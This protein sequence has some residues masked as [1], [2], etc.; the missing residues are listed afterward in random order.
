MK[1]YTKNEAKEWARSFLVGQWSTLV[2]PFDEN[3]LIDEE[4]LRKP[5]REFLLKY[6]R[7]IDLLR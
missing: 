1:N 6:S 2:T 3:G 4:G 5:R 7:I